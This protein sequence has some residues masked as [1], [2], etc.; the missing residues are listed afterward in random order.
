VFLPFGEQIGAGVQGAPRVLERVAGA[1]SVPVGVLLERRR[2]SSNASPA[3]R[4]T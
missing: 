3:N 1:A 2:H 4:T